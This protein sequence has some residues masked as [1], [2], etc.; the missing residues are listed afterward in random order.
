MGLTMELIHV[1]HEV[2]QMWKVVATFTESLKGGE[3]VNYGKSNS[4]LAIVTAQLNP[5]L[6]KLE[7][8]CNWSVIHPVKLSDHFQGTQEADFQHVTVFQ[9]N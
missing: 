4:Y 6:F 5:T 2:E 9:T 1:K 3:H 8:Q 7:W